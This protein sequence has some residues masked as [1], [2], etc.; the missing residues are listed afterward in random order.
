MKKIML[1][2]ALAFISFCAFAQWTT[3][4]GGIYYNSGDVGIGKTNPS[5]TLDVN[6][7]VRL[8]ASTL[9]LNVS[10]TH[11]STNQWGAVADFGD[12]GNGGLRV[13]TD[14]SGDKA[15]ATWAV[16]NTTTGRWEAQATTSV[17]A[18]RQQAGIDGGFTFFTQNAAPVTAGDPLTFNT[19]LRLNPNGNVGVG[20]ANPLSQFQVGDGT[21]MACLGPASGA[22]LNYGAGYLAFNAART[23]STGIWTTHGDGVHNGGGVIYSNVGG[24]MYFS[25]IPSVGGTNQTLADTTI[26]QDIKMMISGADGSVHAKAFYVTL[27]GWPDYVF[28]PSYNL[29][30]LSGVRNYIALNHRLPGMPAA[31]EVNKNGINLGEMD[32]LLTKKL[33]EV[34]LYLLEKDKQLNKQ[35]TTIT[36]LEAQLKLQ[37]QQID[38][39]IKHVG[40]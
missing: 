36:Q 10:I 30:A 35:Q 33:E 5:Y 16:W 14:N 23:F 18:T 34:T 6:G 26:K 13:Y 17:G 1:T 28:M 2:L 31:G 7:Q 15:L 27:S 21:S 39:L 24:N 25:V 12:G 8:T 3:V 40:K 19:T 9:S 22:G 37:Q 20:V 11:P 32:K 29:P 4:S 38:Y